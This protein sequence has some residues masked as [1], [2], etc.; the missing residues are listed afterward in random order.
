MP[1]TSHTLLIPVERHSRVEAGQRIR[2][3]QK[4]DSLGGE[5]VFAAGVQMNFEDCEILREST[6]LSVSPAQGDDRT[7]C[8]YMAEINA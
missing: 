6:C 1:K 8:D 3:F 7:Y 4:R 5:G 2:V